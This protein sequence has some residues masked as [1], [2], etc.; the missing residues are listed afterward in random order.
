MIIFSKYREIFEPQN[1]IF[2]KKTRV[3]LNQTIHNFPVLKLFDIH[4]NDI[5]VSCRDTLQF[6]K[7]IS[8]NESFFD[9]R[10]MSIQGH[11]PPLQLFLINEKH[12]DLPKYQVSE[13]CKVNV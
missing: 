6:L 2:V 3:V 9:E 4:S 8:R 5:L 1:L 12:G 7:A 10:N 13:P 11:R